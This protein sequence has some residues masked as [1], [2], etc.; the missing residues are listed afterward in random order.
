MPGRASVLGFSKRL[1][2]T[3]VV[4]ESCGSA[5]YWA[6]ESTVLGHEVRLT[7]PQR[8]MVH[9]RRKGVSGWLQAER[10]G[11]RTGFTGHVRSVPS[12]LP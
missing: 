10:V 4:I 11:K 6:R 9:G 1:A 3:V 8:E 12:P 7:S 2:P 5:H